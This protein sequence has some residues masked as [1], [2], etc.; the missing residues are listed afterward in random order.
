MTPLPQTSVLYPHRDIRPPGRH[1]SPSQHTDTPIL[2]LTCCCQYSPPHPPPCSRH[3]Y[4]IPVV[5]APLPPPKYRLP[6]PSYVSLILSVCTMSLRASPLP[7]IP[8]TLCIHLILYVGTPIPLLLP[9][10]G[11]SRSGPVF[12]RSLK[13]VVLRHLPPRTIPQL[14][15]L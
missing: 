8:S 3:S 5:A 9:I 7:C 13:Y 6:R 1:L 14:F 10:S 12:P 4:W 11:P 15:C 2:A